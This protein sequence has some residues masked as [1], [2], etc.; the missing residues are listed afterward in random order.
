[1]VAEMTR[2]GKRNYDMI[3][4]GRA[5][6]LRENRHNIDKDNIRSARDVRSRQGRELSVNN[7]VLKFDGLFRDYLDD[8]EKCT[9]RK[10]S[11]IQRNLIKQAVEKNNYMKLNTKQSHAHRSQ[12]NSR[13]SEIIADWE[14]QYH[15]KWPTY[16]EPVFSRSGKVVRNIGS[17]WDCHHIVE[18]SWGGDNKWYNMIPARFPEAHQNG[19]H[20][21][22]GYADSIFN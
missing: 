20:R 8:V 18:C 2:T 19:I 6:V 15:E 10:I 22:G 3:D 5:R 21:K 9:G 14:S 12:Y 17:K 7:R 11:Q 1:M 16:D 13:K 4:R